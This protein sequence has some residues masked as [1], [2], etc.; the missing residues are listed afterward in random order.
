VPVRKRADLCAESVSVG[1]ATHVNGRGADGSGDTE[2]SV[3]VPG[4]RRERARLPGRQRFCVRERACTGAGR[5]G[6]R[7]ADL[8]ES[9]VTHIQSALLSSLAGT[10][11]A[12]DA[13][14]A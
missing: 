4:V 13:R 7:H 6:S 9:A 2:Q 14:N 8:H 12:A 11:T 5:T 10:K 1:M 3:G